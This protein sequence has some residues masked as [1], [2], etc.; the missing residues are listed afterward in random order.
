MTNLIY[1]KDWKKLLVA[2]TS[3]KPEIIF[4]QMWLFMQYYLGTGWNPVAQIHLFT[5]N[6]AASS[7]KLPPIKW[8]LGDYEAHITWLHF[9]WMVCIMKSPVI[10][11]DLALMMSSLKGTWICP[12]GFHL[13]NSRFKGTHNCYPIYW[14]TDVE[15]WIFIKMKQSHFTLQKAMINNRFFQ[16][17][18]LLVYG[19]KYVYGCIM[20]CK[21][22]F[23]SS[24]T[25]NVAISSIYCMWNST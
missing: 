18:A 8:F 3:C 13:Q 16:K 4:F 1:P 20:F 14:I 5:T 22:K 7:G 11:S 23:I 6:N 21:L 2:H 19:R 25:L 17:V 24:Y 10:S 15:H 12:T 9:V